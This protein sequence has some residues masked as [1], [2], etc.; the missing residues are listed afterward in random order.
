MRIRMDWRFARFDWN[1]A[2][3]FLVTVEEGSL[4][5][6]ARALKMAQPTLGRQVAA[7]ERELGV[8]LFERVGRG[9]T[10]TPSGLELV[11]HVRAMGQA[12]GGM[13]LAAT[14]RTEMMEGSVTLTASDVYSAHLLPP[15]ILRLRAAQPGIDI[16]IIASNAISDLRRREADIAIRNTHVDHPDLVARLIKQDTAALYATPAY[17]ESIGHPKTPEDLEGADLIGFERTSTMV[18]WMKSVGWPLTTRHIPVYCQNHLVQWEYTRRGIGIGV[19][20]TWIGDHDPCVRRVVPDMPLIRFPVWLVAHREVLT[21]RRLRLVYDML[22]EEIE[23][24]KA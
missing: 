4:S 23:G 22:V 8:T 24:T 5:A 3:A 18:G 15:V 2:R 11:E 13:S 19:A 21:S 1:H 9:F 20:P 12:A 14:G 16:E 17:I 7:L 6:A 10:L